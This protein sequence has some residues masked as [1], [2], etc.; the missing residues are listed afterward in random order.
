M[1]P[2]LRP[3]EIRRV[4][5]SRSFGGPVRPF[6]ATYECQPHLVA[7]WSISQFWVDLASGAFAVNA[8]A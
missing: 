3:R 1:H 6:A 4:Q 7:S 2:I 8:D 5:R